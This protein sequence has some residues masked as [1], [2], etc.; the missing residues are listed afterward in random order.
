ML[1]AKTDWRLLC[2][3]IIMHKPTKESVIVIDKY[4]SFLIMMLNHPKMKSI[5]CR[6]TTLGELTWS[7]IAITWRPQADTEKKTSR[8]KP[9]I[10]RITDHL[11][12]SATMLLRGILTILAG[13][14][15]TWCGFLLI[16][17]VWYEIARQSRRYTYWT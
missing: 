10:H 14:W 11:H 15:M 13:K 5:V 4:L 3:G 2:N 16:P 6:S 12:K 17:A 1:G 8:W 7:F 9:S